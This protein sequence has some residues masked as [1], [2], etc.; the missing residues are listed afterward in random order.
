MIEQMLFSSS[1]RFLQFLLSLLHC[2][3]ITQTVNHGISQLDSATYS[4]VQIRSSYLISVLLLRE[5]M[6]SFAQMLR[7]ELAA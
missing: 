1:K 5:E 6:V 4:V 7:H 2:C 3:Y